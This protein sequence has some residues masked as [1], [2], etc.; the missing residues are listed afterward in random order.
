[1]YPHRSNLW[2]ES[3]KVIIIELILA[4]HCLWDDIMAHTVYTIGTRFTLGTWYTNCT[5][6]ELGYQGRA[7]ATRVE[8]GAPGFGHE[9]SRGSQSRN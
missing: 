2:F 1:M 5:L 7:L 6:A 4:R 3:A 8:A 9:R